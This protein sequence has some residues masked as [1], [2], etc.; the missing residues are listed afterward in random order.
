MVIGNN[1]DEIFLV[2]VCIY[3]RHMDVYHL[4]D[5]CLVQSTFVDGTVTVEHARDYG[6]THL[7]EVKLSLFFIACNAYLF[8]LVTLC[9]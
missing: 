3:I 2:L 1:F 7:F 6:H 4:I 5:P 8:K 9:F